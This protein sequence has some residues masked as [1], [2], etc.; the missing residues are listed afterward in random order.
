MVCG[1][2]HVFGVLWNYVGSLFVALGYVAFIMMLCRV[3]KLSLLAKV[4]K[5]AFTNYILM[6]LIGTTIFYGHGFGLFG[7]M[8]RSGQL[9]V[10]VCI[11]VVIMV[12]SHLWQTRYYFGPIE[13]LWRYLTYG[14]KPVNRR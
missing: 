12:F 2:F 13:W 11:W 6:T 10:V 1:L 5:M 14:N 3:R 8:E 9:L 7:T 4:G